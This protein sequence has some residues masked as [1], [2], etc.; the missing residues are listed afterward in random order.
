MF[1][2]RGSESLFSPASRRVHTMSKQPLLLPARSRSPPDFDHNHVKEYT[3]VR[4]F[5]VS[6]H[7]ELSRDTQQSSYAR[8]FNLV[9]SG[10][11]HR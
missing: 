8:G 10:S 9:F 6:Q 5:G 11:S 3:R 1:N 4:M 2:S 7:A